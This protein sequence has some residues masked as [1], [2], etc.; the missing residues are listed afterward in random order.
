MGAA[1]SVGATR[2]S[3]AGAK[4]AAAAT[5][6]RG[7]LT[8]VADFMA[9]PWGAAV[10]VGITLLGAFTEASGS[11]S[12][13]QQGFADALEVGTGAI[14]DQTRAWVLNKLE[15]EGVAGTYRKAGGDVN[16]LIDAYL[17]VA[18][19]GDKVA[20]VM[21]EGASAAGV[22]QTEF[23]HL[24]EVIRQG[25]KALDAAKGAARDKA[26]VDRDGADA[27]NAAADAN[28]NLASGLYGVGDAADS[29]AA[30]AQ[31]LNGLLSGI[32]DTQFGLAKAQDD[33]QGGLLKLQDAFAS[34]DKA[35]TKSSAAGDKYAD[36][37]KRQQKIIKDTR[38]Q[39]DDLA[40]AQK[41]AEEEAREAAQAAR[42]RE[43]DALFGKQF[44]VQSTADAF[45]A[46]LAQA[47]KDIAEGGSRSLTGFAE[48][49]LS[50]RERL[51]SIV[52]A[53]QAAI[54][55]ERNQGAGADRIGQLSQGLA[56]QLA[57]S[58]SAWGLNA[59]EVKQYTDAIL[60]F[61]NLA[62]Q[63]VIPDL[64]SVAKSFAEQRQEIQENSAEQMENAK[65][66]AASASAAGGAASAAERH[67][68][69][70]QGNSKSA[71]ENR[72][73]MRQVVKQAQDELTQLHLS[74]AGRD[75]LRRRGEELAAQLESQGIQL[76]FSREDL[77][78]YTDA[79]KVSAE[80]VSRYPTLNAR[81]DVA[82]AMTTIT[83]FVNG[84]NAQMAKIQKDFSIGVHTGSEY[85]NTTGGGH[86][87]FAEGGQVFGPGGPREDKVPAMLS[88]GEFVVNAADAKRNLHLLELINAGGAVRTPG[89]AAGG[90]VDPI[91]LRYFGYPSTG[92]EETFNALR[93]ALQP[94]AAASS[95]PL[96]W[97]ASQAGK[98]YIWGGVGPAG[99]DCSGFQSAITNV[100]QGR[101]PHARR[102]ATGS[103]PT[104]DF[105]RGPGNYM[106][107]YFRGN[108]GHM[109]G[110]L[111][112]VNVESRGGEGVVVGKRARGAHDRLFN[113]NI[114]HLKGYADGGQVE[115]GRV[116]DAPFDL[117]SP[118]G[119]HFAEVL[120]SYA[121]GTDYVPMD[122]LYQLHRGEAVTPA[123]QNAVGPMV[124]EG[125][126]QSDGTRFGDLVTESIN[127]GISTGQIRLARKS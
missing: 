74:G 117:L 23:M 113:N 40:E 46:A 4:V 34:N 30:R 127:K 114:W 97:A 49:A 75:E 90:R 39:L 5:G 108:P 76:G 57:Q 3:G 78:L 60:S 9:G 62:G 101:N 27:A 6:M 64:A 14:T 72:E 105:D 67:T 73:M 81:V 82:G 31:Q 22:S 7:A 33:F 116:G 18:G 126:L 32:F 65:A 12:V 24:L 89:F 38:K 122:G 53:A 92:V 103:F 79:I 87:F 96:Q 61:G 43:L 13:D 52:Q 50:N 99:Y 17:G 95:V 94:Y 84:V 115:R 56:G 109:A 83:N 63:Q 59:D 70:L 77:A 25:P 37:L 11:A 100:I 55:A 44:D 47:G 28:H 85:I 58:A 16:D 80:E 98:P 102:F 112:G 35:A 36:S 69:A 111:M 1:Y 123:S 86:Q 15:T 20:K 88:A 104:G 119:M 71:I 118:L 121:R 124:L 91:N 19:A 26:K 41:K 21:S 54:Q 29:V 68:A 120:G 125:R 45:Q 66:S 106:I 107:G 8:N 10:G 48:G 110:T 2:V 51:R 93:Q 42:Q